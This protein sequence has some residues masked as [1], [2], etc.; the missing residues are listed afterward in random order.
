M[1]IKRASLLTGS[2]YLNLTNMMIPGLWET[3]VF[4]N[5]QNA[6]PTVSQG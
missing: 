3:A 4:A 6:Y 2:F 5:D 1:K